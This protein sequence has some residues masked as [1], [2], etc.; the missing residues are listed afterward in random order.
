[1]YEGEHPPIERIRRLGTLDLHWRLYRRLADFRGTPIDRKIQLYKKLR[2]DPFEVMNG[3]E[4]DPVDV[5]LALFYGL[6]DGGRVRIDHPGYYD[7]QIEFLIGRLWEI[8]SLRR[9]DVVEFPSIPTLE[10]LAAGGN[11]TNVELFD[12]LVAKGVIQSFVSLSQTMRNQQLEYN[13]FSCRPGGHFTEQ[14]HRWISEVL[15]ER[16][17][18]EIDDH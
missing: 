8:P 11:S 18:F 6:V 9:I 4:A 12:N 14:G 3:P 7:A 5:F 17:S 10:I 2:A 1:V 16:L 13:D 15:L